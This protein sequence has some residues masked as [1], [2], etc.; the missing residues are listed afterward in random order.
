MTDNIEKTP[1]TP[2]GSGRVQVLFGGSLRDFFLP[3]ESLVEI[4][5][6]VDDSVFTVLN[7]LMARTAR[8]TWIKS[9]MVKGLI[10]G[11]VTIG[12]ANGLFKLH[13]EEKGD[14]VNAAVIASIVLVNAV[15][16]PVLDDDDP[17]EEELGKLMG[18]TEN[19][20]D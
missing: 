16:G 10:G 6:E 17:E 20:P 19:A 15:S 13:I 4:E 12:E 11:G 9:V 2:N 8:T 14:W 1:E 7:A 18:L 3:T 5:Q